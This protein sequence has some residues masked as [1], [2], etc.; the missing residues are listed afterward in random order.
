MNTLEGVKGKL[1]SHKKQIGQL[2]SLMGLIIIVLF[3]G[4]ITLLATVGTLV[5]NAHIWGANTY[6]VLIKELN[7]NNN[8]IDFFTNKIDFLTNEINILQSSQKNNCNIPA[9][10]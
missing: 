6:Q 3:V 10:K 5:W 4:F 2:N 7:D 8:K 9:T 1:E